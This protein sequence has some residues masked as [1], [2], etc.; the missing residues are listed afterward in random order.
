[1]PDIPSD[2][3]AWWLVWAYPPQ[4]TARCRPR[5]RG[6]A[7]GSDAARGAR[8]GAT[9]FGV[10]VR[11]VGDTLRNAPAEWIDAAGTRRS[12][13]IGAYPDSRPG[14]RT[15]IDKLRQDIRYALRR[16][17]PPSGLRDCRDPHAGARASART[18]RC[19]AS[20]TPCC[21]GRCRT[22]TAIASP[23]CG[24][25]RRRNPHVADVLAGIR[26]APRRRRARSTRQ[27]CGSAR[28]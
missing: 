17:A 19:S 20:S 16:L 25:G 15:M 26:R 28:A 10:W 14:E 23:R 18:P 11:A 13:D 9:R 2:A 21:C 12:A 22:R 1:M 24:G 3:F 4:F 5:P 6:R 27:R 8:A 7:R